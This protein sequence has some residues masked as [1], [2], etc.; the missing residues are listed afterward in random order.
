VGADKE[1][2]RINCSFFERKVLCTIYGPKIV[3]CTGVGTIS[4]WINSP[5]AEDLPQRARW[6]DGGMLDF[7]LNNSH[8]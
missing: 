3:V 5:N 1:G 2:K 4:N 6:A 7:N 8:L